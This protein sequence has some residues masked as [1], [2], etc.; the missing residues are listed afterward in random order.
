MTRPRGA[1]LV[2]GALV[3]V[4]LT[5]CAD[6]VDPTQATTQVEPYRTDP[7]LA[8]VDIGLALV[9]QPA[10]LDDGRHVEGDSHGRL[11][12]A[13]LRFAYRFEVPVGSDREA[14]LDDAATELVGRGWTLDVTGTD[15]R[16]LSI[17]DHREDLR[18]TIVMPTADSEWL[19]QEIRVHR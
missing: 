17:R 7:L 19:V 10:S 16:V 14:L 2:G 15:V 6:A 12:R 4:L 9:D 13:D 1:P 3:A 8:P 5:G 11:D 18:T